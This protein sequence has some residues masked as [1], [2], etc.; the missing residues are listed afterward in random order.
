MLNRILLNATAVEGGAATTTAPAGNELVEQLVAAIMAKKPAET[1][2]EEKRPEEKKPAEVDA[3]K[4]VRAWLQDLEGRYAKLKEADAKK[5]EEFTEQ[6]LREQLTKLIGEGDV[7][8]LKTVLEKYEQHFT[9]KLTEK[10]TLLSAK[11]AKLQTHVKKSVLA[12][13]LT[14][15][16]FVNQNAARDMI[17]KVD[18]FTEVKYD[19]QGEPVVVEKGTGKPIVEAIKIRH[20]AGEFDH[21]LEAGSRGVGG[22]GGGDS[23]EATPR[24]DATADDPTAWI[25]AGLKAQKGKLVNGLSTGL[26]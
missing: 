22:T 21:F 25:A 5:S 17:A 6:K 9:A 11:D 3:S 2:V 15:L 7:A 13:A 10:E 8:K 14:G 23:A 20:E 4:D 1:K 24:W 16:K 26:F 18:G 19:A 12:E